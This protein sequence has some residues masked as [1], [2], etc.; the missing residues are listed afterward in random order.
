MLALHPYT[1]RGDTQKLSVTVRHSKQAK[2]LS[3]FYCLDALK[4]NKVRTG[5]VMQ[6]NRKHSY[7][8]DETDMKIHH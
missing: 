8:E 3:V 4:L 7:V 6:L 1:S 2:T 5:R